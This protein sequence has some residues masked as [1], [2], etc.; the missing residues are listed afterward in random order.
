ML[1]HERLT[2]VFDIRPDV[3][4]LDPRRIVIVII[5]WLSPIDQA[6]KMAKMC[7]PVCGPLRDSG[8]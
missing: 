7:C 6:G 8:I 2:T 5:L 1:A 3:F 4:R